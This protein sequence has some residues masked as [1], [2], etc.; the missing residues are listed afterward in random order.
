MAHMASKRDP[1]RSRRSGLAGLLPAAC[2]LLGSAALVSNAA[3]APDA[4]TGASP[5]AAAASAPALTA[6]STGPE[7]Y[8]ILCAPC[9]RA[10][11]GGGAAA[12]APSLINPTIQDRASG[13]IQRT[14]EATGRAGTSM[15]ATGK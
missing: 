15:G 5:L 2:L 7:L 12:H 1:G 14:A 6:H 13:A 3:A 9:H 8:A 4:S 11:G 10:D